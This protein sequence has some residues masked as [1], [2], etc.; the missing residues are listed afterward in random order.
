MG[1]QADYIL[2][3][4]DCES[5]GMPFRGAGNGYPRQCGACRSSDAPMVKASAKT[6]RCPACTRK[7]LSDFSLQQ[8]RTAKAH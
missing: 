8:H 5:C 3:G 4:D 7:F 6:V 2:N 1:E